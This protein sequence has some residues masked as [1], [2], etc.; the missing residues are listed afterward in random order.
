MSIFADRVYHRWQRPKM[1]S[2]PSLIKGTHAPKGANM[3]MAT[4]CISAYLIVGLVAAGWIW[5]ALMAS[6]QRDDK[7][8][9]V[10]Y[11]HLHYRPFQERNTKSV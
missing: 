6:K 11:E 8:K 9:N 3:T 1:L 4:I 5:M 10:S 7:A 2:S